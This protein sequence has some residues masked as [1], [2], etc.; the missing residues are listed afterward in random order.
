[1]KIFLIGVALFYASMG[2]LLLFF[3]DHTAT[4]MVLTLLPVNIALFWIYACV[5]LTS[6]GVIIASAFKRNNAVLRNVAIQAMLFT[7]GTWLFV[8]LCSAIFFK[9]AAGGVLSWAFILF[10]MLN[11]VGLKERRNQQDQILRTFIEA[12]AKDANH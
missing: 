7:C 2:G 12:G 8:A 5:F 9:Q 3:P 10:M 1:M 6:A 11:E 4:G